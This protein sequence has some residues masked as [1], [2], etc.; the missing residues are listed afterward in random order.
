MKNEH[1]PLH[2]Q[3]H[4]QNPLRAS[5]FAAA[6]NISNAPLLKRIFKPAG[7]KKKTVRR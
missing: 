6:A 7:V 4:R 3:T 5:R 2:R 1:I